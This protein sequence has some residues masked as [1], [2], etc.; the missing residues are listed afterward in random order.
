MAKLPDLGPIF[1]IEARAIARRW[2]AY[3]VRSLFIA[4]IFA[5]LAFAF[6]VEKRDQSTG[7]G[8]ARAGFF[9]FSA[10]T[11]TQLALVMLVAPA[12]TAGGFC[13][14][15][16][17]G[18]LAHALVTDLTSV[19]IVLAKLLARLVPV[20][21]LMACGV[22][23]MIVAARLGGVE[24][25]A[26]LAGTLMVS[27]GAVLGCALGLAFSVWANR[28]DEALLAT[29]AVLVAW[30]A[31][32]PGWMFFNRIGWLLYGPP[33]W[34]SGSNPVL[35]IVGLTTTVSVE[36]LNV[37]L[38]S[39]GMLAVAA[40]AAGLAIATLRA[41]EG[42]FAEWLSIIPG[43]RAFRR[44]CWRAR[45][46]DGSHEASPS[47]RE[48]SAVCP[49]EAEQQ[50]ASGGSA[51]ARLGAERFEHLQPLAKGGR[52]G[53]IAPSP[54][55][56]WLSPLLDR[57]PILWREWQRRRATGWV[58]WIWVLYDFCAIAAT[59]TIITLVIT[60]GL[61]ISTRFAS[62]LNG[63][64]V[65]AGMLLLAV[66]AT[67]S[68]AE[69]RAG[70]GLEVL[71]ST[72]LESRSILLAKWWGAF[73]TVVRLAILPV[74]AALV[75]ACYSGRFEGVAAIAGV[76]ICYGAALTSFGLALA[77]WLPRPGWAATLGV[78]A[79]VLVTIGWFFVAV[80]ATSGKALTG[81]GLA[82]GSPFIAVSI[83]TMA[84]QDMPLAVWH[85]FIG[86]LVFW[87]A[88]N[89]GAAVVMLFA[90]LGSFN[91]CLG[92]VTATARSRAR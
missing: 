75:V 14:G 29:Y 68:F 42:G 39:A 45:V 62:L 55:N 15:A 9:F 82:A 69:E 20:L 53:L 66:R 26:L 2:Q 51:A 67:T 76:V 44:D 18:T 40:V 58:G 41:T 22:P 37:S 23:V 19:E 25:D 11:I 24:P 57:N 8:T 83:A 38:L 63:L 89:L 54:G 47:D 61:G 48:K 84:M 43:G 79:H 80:V 1:S 12:A 71:L 74:L 17:R 73:G 13:R 64:Q 65:A 59:A 28:T 91:R 88:I 90:T 7:G 86:W 4:G 52:E 70:G 60:R 16:A 21:A 72:P 33:D 32:C 81:M 35:V 36:W 31:A 27:S 3:A 46:H 50:S 85:E 34:L 77:V 56:T 30:V 87:M 6:W 78:A 10:I 5:A 92:R 49:P